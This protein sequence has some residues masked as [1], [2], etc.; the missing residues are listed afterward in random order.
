MEGPKQEEESKGEVK[1]EVEEEGS[2][3]EVKV[4]VEVEE[5]GQEEL[6]ASLNIARYQIA[7]DWL[8]M[9]VRELGE[10]HDQV[11]LEW[12]R[13]VGEEWAGMGVIE[14]NEGLC[15]A[16]KEWEEFERRRGGR[17]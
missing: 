4:E 3:A 5:G 17:R 9:V 16:I 6:M 15:N 2:K 14:G 7:Q 12:W 11:G 8:K 13:R 10:K 1:V